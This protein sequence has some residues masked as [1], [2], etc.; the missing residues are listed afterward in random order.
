MDAEE[1][2]R[3]NRT[4]R[5]DLQGVHAPLAD[6]LDDW[7]HAQHGILS[8]AHAVGSFLADLAD[9]GLQVV[10]TAAPVDAGDL[11]SALRVPP[12]DAVMGTLTARRTL[13]GDILVEHVGGPLLSLSLQMFAQQHDGPRFITVRDGAV[14]VAG[15]DA[16][17][18]PAELRY[19]AVGLQLADPAYL[20]AQEGGYLLLERLEQ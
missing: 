12:P 5:A 9:A 18:A 7:L 10:P 2:E 15:V 14:V 3:I 8:S 13:A 4:P 11:A 1:R 17:G 6:A 19:R 16:D 20:A